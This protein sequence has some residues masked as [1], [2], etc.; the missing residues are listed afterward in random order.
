MKFYSTGKC[1]KILRYG[2]RLLTRKKEKLTDSEQRGFEADLRLLDEALLSGKKEEA[3]TYAKR[4]ESFIKQHFPK[5]TFDH[6]KEIFFA[7]AFAIIVAF[8][9][10]QFW[11]E[12]YEV[13]TGSMRP[14]VAELDRLVVSK[15][16]FGINFPFHKKPILFSPDYIQRAGIIVFTTADMDIQD[17]NMMYFGIFPG[18]KRYIKRCIA[19]PGDT[20]YFYGGQVYG[21]DQE[22][23]PLLDLANKAFL[24]ANGIERID[25][26]PYITFDGK[27]TTSQRVAQNLYGSA[28]IHQMN[29]PVGKLHLEGK[30]IAEG[31]FFNGTKWVVDHPEA[32]KAP[33]DVPVSYSDLWGIGN[34]AM[35]RL[36]TKEEVKTFYQESPK[37]EALLYLELRHTPN[38]TFPKPEIRKDEQGRYHPM[39]TPYV[40][41]I[42]LKK[43]H[44]ESLQK[45]LYTARFIVKDGRAF[46]YHEGNT[47]PQR[48]EFDID[49]PH[50]PNGTYEFYYG[51]GYRIHFGG[52]RT[53]LPADHPLY[54]FSEENIRT[55]FNQGMGFN[56]LFEPV[57]PNQTFN[58]QRFAYYRDGDLFVMGAPILKKNDPV[59]SN[60]IQNEQVKQD[61]SSREAP[62][63]AFIDHGP[64]L[65][66][67]VLDSEFIQ[68]FG[69]RAPETGLIALGDNYAMSADSRDFGFVPTENLRGAPSFTFWPPGS[70]LGGLPQPS[71]PWLT[72]PNCLVWLAAFIIILATW[73]YIRKRNRQSIFDRKK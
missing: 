47:R 57:A 52:I 31:Q 60:F 30:S 70:R 1:R 50:V 64:P 28:T 24:K 37:E 29:L 34:Y 72:L 26:I 39:I 46:R 48:P 49:L 25:H 35:A 2:H 11:F 33:H 58:P 54:S 15:T 21:I 4:V 40:A 3:V 59:L 41:L 7:L 45:A 19:K 9:I 23:K 73:L 43:S 22:G 6:V 10:R 14:T 62:Y 8:C 61:N 20:V 67:G 38:L 65:K 17:S 68:A 51:V 63:I 16:T 44:L 69:L 18:K 13:P 36:L 56:L 71:Y 55:L 53:E 12:L 66:N 42:P 27:A 32:L 5:S